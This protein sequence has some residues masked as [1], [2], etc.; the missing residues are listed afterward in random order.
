MHSFSLN[1]LLKTNNN[2]QN[3]KIVLNIMSKKL[4]KIST[5]S[6][7]FSALK[8]A[9]WEAEGSSEL[10][11]SLV[12]LIMHIFNSRNWFTKRQFSA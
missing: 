12:S 8:Q 6:H 10:I 1:T 7:K 4:A 5:K 9:K 2:K 11:V 3:N